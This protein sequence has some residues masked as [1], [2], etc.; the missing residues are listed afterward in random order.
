MQDKLEL[1]AGAGDRTGGPSA[2]AD[3]VSRAVRDLEAELRAQGGRRWLRRLIVVGVLV[4]LVAGVVF[5]RQATAPPPPPR[6][7]T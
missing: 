1:G 3:A 2:G 4:A 5:W 7:V 6:F